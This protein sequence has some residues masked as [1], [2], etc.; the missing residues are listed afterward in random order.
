MSVYTLGSF[1]I[2]VAA[3]FTSCAVKEGVV[4]TEVY[5]SITIFIPWASLP[6]P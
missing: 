2:R 5:I 1:I 6:Y 4:Y 3:H